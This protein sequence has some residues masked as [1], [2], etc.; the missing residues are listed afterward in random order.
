M[1][2]IPLIFIHQNGLFIQETFAG[3]VLMFNDIKTKCIGLMTTSETNIKVLLKNKQKPDMSFM[4]DISI[5]GQGL[6]KNKKN[7]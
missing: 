2:N 5:K 1:Y 6:I 3:W 4:N 7:Y